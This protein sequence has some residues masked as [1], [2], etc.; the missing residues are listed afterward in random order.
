MDLKGLENR[1]I[2]LLGKSRAFSEAEFESQLK[3]HKISVIKKYSDD[4]VL[5]VEGGM[6]NPYEQNES[7]RLYEEKDI[8]FISIDEFERKLASGLDLNTL[9]MS[10]K[11]SHDKD[12][13]KDF[14]TNTMI[15][16]EVFLKL[17][18]IYNWGGEDF[19]DN[20]DN[21]DIS[22]A[23]IER[24]YEDIERNHNVAYATTG[25]Y[26]LA[27]QAKD[28]KLL[29]EIYELKPVK[30]HSSIKQSIAS[31]VY[32]ENTLQNKLY[33]S[34]EIDVLEALSTN[35]KLTRSLA[36]KFL[37]DEKLASNVAKNIILDYE[38]F[39]MFKNYKASLALN[40]TLT[41]E[42]QKELFTFKDDEINHNLALNDFIDATIINL[43]FSLCDE[44]I[45]NLLYQNASTPQSI[46][47]DAYKNPVYHE[48]LSKN[49]NTPIEILYQLLLDAR[50]E[51][52]VKS[53]P[54]FAK[55]I[56]TENIGWL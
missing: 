51:R 50:C 52:Y 37:E 14:L 25:F 44:N 31:N 45:N 29:S 16:D 48:K 20:D 42:M 8:S 27:K 9:M 26:H 12:R 54:A 21:R 3:Y 43:L 7:D 56:Q 46:L 53:N 39:E 41:L 15:V 40:Y 47:E 36:E 23:F 18:R 33:K 55:H 6:M 11:L 1:T 35:K 4:T 32:C 2:L 22:A 5:I 13:L 30:F 19:F 34:G 38:L 17:L 10:L 49:Q 28:S 24:F